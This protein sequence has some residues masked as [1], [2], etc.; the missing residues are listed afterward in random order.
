MNCLRRL[1]ASMCISLAALGA[2]ESNAAPI[3]FAGNGHWYEFVDATV[4][5]QTALANAG[6]A[7][8]TTCG[9]GVLS[10]YLV[11][12]T[13]AAENDFVF[14]SVAPS[15]YNF[16]LGGSDAAQEGT[17][18]WMAGPELGKSFWTGGPAGTAVGTDTG[19][20]NWFISEPN[21]ANGGEQ[22]LSSTGTSASYG[23]NDLCQTATCTQFGQRYAYVIEYSGAVPEPGSLCLVAMSAFL[24]LSSRRLVRS[25][26]DGSHGFRVQR[27]HLET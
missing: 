10:G 2:W 4:D 7:T 17:W 27:T 8:C 26:P 13:S 20:A 25:R 18:R 14:G 21:N 5:W 1:P 9:S 23:W 6:A 12:I 19:F 24:G 16:W 3:Q 15:P 11:T 22:Y